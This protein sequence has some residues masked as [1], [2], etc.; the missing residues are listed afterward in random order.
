MSSAVRRPRLSLGTLN[1][2]GLRSKRHTVFHMKRER[3]DGVGILLRQETHHG[4]PQEAEAWEREGAGPGMPWMGHSAW[5]QGTRASCGVGV[6]VAPWVP[7]EG[8]EVVHRDEGG[9]FLAVRFTLHGQRVLLV[10]VYAPATDGSD[11]VAF[12]ARVRGVVAPLVGEEDGVVLVGGDFNCVE[13]GDLDVV[14]GQSVTRRAGFLDGLQPVQHELGLVDVFRVMHPT[15]REFTH[16][17]AT[18]RSAARLDRWLVGEGGVGMVTQ[19]DVRDGWPGDHRLARLSLT[20]PEG[21]LRGEGHW[22]F[23][24]PLLSDGPFRSALSTAMAEWLAAR[25]VGGSLTHAVRWERF[26][27]FVREFT[28]RFSLER[29]RAQRRGQ[30]E[31]QAAARAAAAEWGAS[32]SVEAA[33]RFAQGRQDLQ[34]EG[35]RAASKAAF[36]AGIKWEDDGEGSTRWF[37]R[38]GLRRRADTTILEL[39]DTLSPPVAVVD[40]VPQYPVLS[41]ATEEGRDRAGEVI[42]AITCCSTSRRLSTSMWHS[43]PGASP[44]SISRRRTIGW[45]VAGWWHAWGRSGLAQW[46]SRGCSCCCAGQWRAAYLMAGAPPLSAF[47]RGWRRAVRSPRCCTSSR[48]SRW[49]LACASYRGRASCGGYHCR[50][51]PWH[52][53]HTSTRMTRRCMLRTLR[54]W[55]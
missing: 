23:P 12:F 4:S 7:V 36:F 54:T 37:H 41:L 30:R 21:V 33:Q 43:S 5:A 38:L 31:G 9:R 34:E 47:G 3:V 51:G 18:S 46:P 55:A 24:L 29:A 35:A 25:P 45:I 44:S 26:K 19:A 17:A 8:W 11:R 32:G 48:L 14:S 1:V 28:Q 2:N 22:S 15:A 50:M 40:G 53:R 16:V 20:F 49:P 42:A 10:S 6:L 52:R 27:F 13:D 39:Q